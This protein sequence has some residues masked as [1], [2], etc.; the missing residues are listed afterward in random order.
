MKSKER[1][2][3][4]V[5]VL[6]L[7][8]AIFALVRTRDANN[9]QASKSSA[10]AEQAPLIDQTPL[11]T[12]QQFAKMSTSAEEKP[13]A[14]EALH[15]GD[16]EMDLAFAAAVRDAQ[17]H[18]PVL[19]AE[20]KKIQEH[21]HKAEDALDADKKRVDQ[22]TADDAKATGSRKDALD[23]QLD[24]AKAQLELD[25]D[26]ADESK[27]DLLRAGGDP[28]SRIQAMTDEHEAASHSSDATK[29]TITDPVEASGLIHRF[30]QW[31]ALHK[32][33]L[34]LWRAKQDAET[35]AAAFSA[36][37][38]AL[39][40]QVN[41]PAAQPSSPAVPAG[42]KSAGPTR[43][44]FVAMAQTTRRRANDQKTLTN[45]DKRI[46]DQQQLAGVYAA[47]ISVVSAKQR[48]VLH[49]AI[50]GITIVLAILLIGVFFDGWLESLLGK[51]SLDRR[52]VETLRTVTRVTLQVLAFLFIL[53]VIFGPPN[54]I[55]T[56][57]GLAGAGLTVALKDF[58]VG[59]LGWF[60]LMGKNGIRLGDW[61]EINGVTG[62]VV[63]LG[64]F[65]TVLLETG[66]WT[67]SS[68]PTGRRVT[69][70]N[71]F[72]I[73]GHYFNF[74]TSGQWLWDE[75][76]IIVPTGLDPYPIVTA[77]QKKVLEATSEGAEKA[78]LEWK[79]AAKS[80]DL[81]TRT[82]VPAVNLKPVIGGIE[83]SVRYITRAN[84]RYQLR[85]QLYQSAVELM[86]G[87]SAPALPGA[88][89]VPAK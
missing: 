32:K 68:H 30:Q 84:E 54:Q 24:V 37:H 20:A 62:E 36:K 17:M 2:V 57:L 58:I 60:V 66:N 69:F 76:Q 31:S 89:D 74:S 73:E 72:A 85:A 3:A 26:E 8:A 38:A 25:Q 55:G 43:D 13:F 41:A 35:S 12:A 59:F 21:L 28:Q 11:L 80:R 63:E 88:T 64:M 4:I 51:T 29:V 50:L 46:D 47:W 9:Q 83:I 70:T 16:Q 1:A 56:V 18:P 61:V 52:Q 39:E 15:L 45:L 78:E 40:S 44:E 6:L 42:K 71:S 81:N 49:Q 33:Q 5:L 22:L 65:H 87:K 34:Q 10:S 7:G 14:E 67:D 23:D 27:Q 86:G 75:L 19:T 82:A 79:T 77:I 48:T 53:L